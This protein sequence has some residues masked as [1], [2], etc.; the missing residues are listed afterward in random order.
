MACPPGTETFHLLLAPLVFA[1]PGSRG[2]ASQQAWNNIACALWGADPVALGD[3]IVSACAQ[4]DD[5]SN[6][7]CFDT[8]GMQ[9][10][11]TAPAP[12]T[13]LSSDTPVRPDANAVATDVTVVAPSQR[14]D[15]GS[16]GSVAGPS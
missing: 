3:Q 11:A 2:F 13:L 10:R 1:A 14:T 7:P 16:A 15:A 8:A 12:F 6:S 4:P 9:R 5:P